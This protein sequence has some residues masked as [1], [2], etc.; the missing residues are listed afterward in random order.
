MFLG[1]QR[2]NADYSDVTTHLLSVIIK[3]LCL[4]GLL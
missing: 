1:I 4:D 2:V 3:I